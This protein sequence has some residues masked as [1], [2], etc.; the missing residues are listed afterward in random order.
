MFPFQKCITVIIQNRNSGMYQGM[1]QYT[2]SSDPCHLYLH[3]YNPLYLD[4]ISHQNTLPVCHMVLT[5][6]ISIYVCTSHTHCSQLTPQSSHSKDLAHYVS[7]EST[8]TIKLHIN[9]MLNKD[10][11]KILSQNTPPV[12]DSHFRKF[13]GKGTFFKSE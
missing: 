5:R 3:S 13:R 1:R 7:L 4:I 8:H 12:T 2:Y 9:Y 6:T 11:N 10:V